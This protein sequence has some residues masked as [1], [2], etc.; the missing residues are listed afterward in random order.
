MSECI[1]C[2]IVKK[3]VKADNIFEDEKII[4]F[5][6]INPK[7]PVH[8]L[9]VPK[10]HINSII[11]M[12]EGDKEI[13]SDLIWRAKEIAREKGLSGYKLIFNCG[14]EGGQE[15]NHIHLHLLSGL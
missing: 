11:T 14:K 12:E 6:D 4:A 9:V 7:A 5:N 10:K 3:E 1:F 2:K 8:I 15:I 13:I